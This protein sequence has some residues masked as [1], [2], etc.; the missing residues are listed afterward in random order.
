MI[1]M[2]RLP[3]PSA[4]TGAL[5]A[6]PLALALLLWSCD[7]GNGWTDLPTGVGGRRDSAP[8]RVDIEFP[9]VTQRV[10]VQDSVLVRVHVTDD[11]GVDSLVLSG[12]SRRGVRALGTDSA[13]LRFVPKTISLKDLHGA[14]DTIISR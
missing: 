4:R 8:P 11:V 13:V 2:I 10:A 9:D 3:V 1:R 6:R 12:F 14:R 5:W 7:G